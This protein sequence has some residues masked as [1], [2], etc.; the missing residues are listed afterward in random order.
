MTDKPVRVR[1]APSPTGRLHVGGARTALYNWA[2]ARAMGG[3]FILRIEDTDPERSTEENVQVILNAMK[4]LNLDWDEGPEVGGDAGPYF[5][6]QRFDTY[7][8]A[9]ERLKDRGAVYPCFCSKELL[10][11][12]RAKAEAEEIL[13]NAR[14]RADSGV[15]VLQAE[16]KE[17]ENEIEMLRATAKDYKERF[18]RLI[19]DQQHVLNA[20]TKLFE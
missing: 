1:F 14:V 11:Q 7:K 13:K 19:E 18:L 15:E 17:L 6:T 12:K 4:W 20:E 10:D 9:L 16:K 8:T 3:T 2:F 5:Q